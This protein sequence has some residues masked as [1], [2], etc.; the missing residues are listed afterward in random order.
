MKF[1]AVLFMSAALLI[2]QPTG[3]RTVSTDG[4]PSDLH[5]KFY[6]VVENDQYIC[7]AKQNA[8]QTTFT[9]TSI[10]LGTL[11]TV[12]VSSGH[13]FSLG[14]SPVINVTGMTG[15]WISLNGTWSAKVINSTQF[16]IALDSSGF[17]SVAGTFN[18]STFA[19]RGGSAIWAVKKIAGAFSTLSFEGWA[20]NGFNNTCLS[21]TVGGF[22]YQ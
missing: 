11:T 5:T 19:N 10:T 14:S 7:Y 8:V 6:L 2:A 12:T 22:S 1:L 18:A 15:S 13:G 3:T 21:S 16:T 4:P 9:A 20:V 17:G